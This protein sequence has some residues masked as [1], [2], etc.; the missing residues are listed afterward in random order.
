MGT[1]VR[2][3]YLRATHAG[4]SVEVTADAPPAVDGRRL[5]FLVRAVDG[6]GELVATGEIDRAMVDR[7]RFLTAV[8]DADGWRRAGRRPGHAGVCP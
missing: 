7:E 6:S 3:R 2:I 8:S 4:G 1:A 5:T